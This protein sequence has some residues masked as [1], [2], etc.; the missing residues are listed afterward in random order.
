MSMPPNTKFSS[1]SSPFGSSDHSVPPPK[2]PTA[3][4]KT[5]PTANEALA[6]Q[7]GG[8]HRTGWL[9]YL[10][11]HWLPYIQL[12]RLSPPVGLFLVFFPH[13]FGLL[14]GAVRQKAS[15]P[16]LLQATVLLFGGSFFVSNAIHIWNDLI[17]APLDAKV[18]RTRNRP[19]PRGAVTT[20]A[21]LTFTASQALG[22]LLFVF[23]LDG[24]FAQNALF[25]APGA[26]AWLYYPYAKRHTY[27]TQVVLGVCLSW[28]VFMGAVAMGIK[29]YS[30]QAG[31]VDMP[32]FLLFAASAMWTM[33]YDS[34][35]GFQDL[36]DDL[37][38]GIYSMAVLFQYNIKPVFW[39]LVG[40]ITVLLTAIGY[41]DGMGASYY[42]ITVG[43][44]SACLGLMVGYVDLS[45]SESCWWWFAKGFWYVGGS[46]MGG[47]FTEY[48][49]IT[50]SV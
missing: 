17:D 28:G 36:N 43:I 12:V 8:N 31:T 38:A 35:Y 20:T 21:A 30:L 46:I 23:L 26:I 50:L 7:Y 5:K 39:M 9:A 45:S 47:L 49:K 14:Y 11:S 27:W 42:L 13:A 15:P 33:I 16:M 37:D 6:Y 1:S 22:A 41:G 34:V 29:P 48:L 3:P 4:K 25:S 10:P 32:L 44:T 2:M 19:I 24:E 40:L 18:E